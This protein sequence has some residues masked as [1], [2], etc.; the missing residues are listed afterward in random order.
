MIERE[1]IHLR[2]SRKATQPPVIDAVRV[3]PSALQH[4]AIDGDLA[5]AERLQIC[6]GAQAAADQALNFLCAAG[7][8]GRRRSRAACAYASRAGSMAYSAVTQPRPWPR[9]HCGGLSSSEAV[10]STCV[11]PNLMR[12]GA[13]GIARDIAF[14]D[15]GPHLIR[16]AFGK[17]AFSFN[18]N[19]WKKWPPA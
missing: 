12:Q 10:Q 6:D 8:A 19:R 13:F 15:H 2:H 18:L 9:N 14:D 11:S 16:R 7:R 4:I 5:F 3:P 17:D 1:C